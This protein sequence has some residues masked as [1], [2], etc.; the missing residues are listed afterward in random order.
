M[1]HTSARILVTSQLFPIV[2]KSLSLA[3]STQEVKTCPI[4]C[5]CMHW[6]IPYFP[7]GMD[8]LLSFLTVWNYQVPEDGN[9]IAVP[10]FFKDNFSYLL[11]ALDKQSLLCILAFAFSLLQIQHKPSFLLV[12]IPTLTIFPTCF[13]PKI[14]NLRYSCNFSSFSFYSSEE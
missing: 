10:Y 12:L 1:F 8:V 13:N 11:Q 2:H 6:Y 4:N 9:P 5:H 14:D 3:C 7:Y